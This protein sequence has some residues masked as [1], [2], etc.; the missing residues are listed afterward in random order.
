[1][2]KS[3]QAEQID[4]ILQLVVENI[5]RGVVLSKK[6]HRVE[7]PKALTKEDTER[8]VRSFCSVNVS[9][10]CVVVPSQLRKRDEGLGSH[11]QIVPDA[12]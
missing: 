8:L 2:N 9:K 6:G 5:H 1:M 11:L 10:I 3:F 7:V 12:C 4:D